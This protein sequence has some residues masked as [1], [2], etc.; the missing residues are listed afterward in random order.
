MRGDLAPTRNDVS[1]A[2]QRRNDRQQPGRHC[3]SRAS[4]TAGHADRLTTASKFH[5]RLTVSMESSS[6]IQIEMS[7]PPGS[8]KFASC[9]GCSH[10]TI[11]LSS[12]DE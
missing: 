5:V 3:R 6:S 9:S 2:F 7:F 12:D 1:E 11:R 8:V 10:S 4:K